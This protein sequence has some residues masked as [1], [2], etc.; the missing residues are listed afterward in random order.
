M[1]T[2]SA[3]CARLKAPECTMGRAGGGEGDRTENVGG[4]CAHLEVGADSC[5]RTEGALPD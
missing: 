2:L 4:M 1:L 3:D 5:V